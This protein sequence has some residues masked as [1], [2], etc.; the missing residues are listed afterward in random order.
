MPFLAQVWEWL[1][2]A[3]DLVKAEVHQAW[4]LL[5]ATPLPDFVASHLGWVSL[6]LLTLVSILLA[7]YFLYWPYG[8]GYMSLDER[9]G[10]VDLN[11]LLARERR[12]RAEERARLLAEQK[13]KETEAKRE[14][15]KRE[16]ERRRQARDEARRKTANA[17]AEA[18][19]VEDMHRDSLR[20]AAGLTA[21]ERAELERQQAAREAAYRE[22]VARA[23]LAQAI[24]EQAYRVARREAAKRVVD[25]R[26]AVKARQNAFWEAIEVDVENDKKRGVHLPIKAPLPD[27][28]PLSPGRVAAPSPKP[29]QP[30]HPTGGQQYGYAAQ[31]IDMP[32]ASPDAQASPHAHTPTATAK[33]SPILYN[34]KDGAPADKPPSHGGRLHERALKKAA[35]VLERG[36][37]AAAWVSPRLASPSKSRADKADKAATPS[38]KAKPTTTT[39]TT[40][41]TTGAV[42]SAEA[43]LEAATATAAAAAASSAPTPPPKR[44]LSVLE[45]RAQRLARG[46]VVKQPPAAPEP[47]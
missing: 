19:Q 17:L 25:Y 26:A 31:L 3:W 43:P 36:K 28:R 38:A 46:G 30:A 18:K 34:P 12:K 23:A 13:R 44:G 1:Q 6:G 42:S 4:E 33:R 11:N 32:L 16:E 2:A 40:G 20:D 29:V 14:E 39:P 35:A 5:E 37:A 15:A 41:A 47:S 7:R 21:A 24:T 10:P 9:Y 8:N 27:F 22:A 45:K